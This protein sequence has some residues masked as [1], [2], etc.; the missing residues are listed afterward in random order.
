MKKIK[1]VLLKPLD[2][3]EIGSE[4]EFD[5]VDFDRLVS[6]GAVKAATKP[7]NK[8][9]PKP[10]NKAAKKPKNKSEG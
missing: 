8:A 2:G 1:A 9:A 4:R 3:A 7:E 10:R 6:R 5:E